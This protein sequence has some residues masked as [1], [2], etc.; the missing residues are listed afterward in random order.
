MHRGRLSIY[1]LRFLPLRGV[2]GDPLSPNGLRSGKLVT[3]RRNTSASRPY[4]IWTTRPWSEIVS[5]TYPTKP[6]WQG[7]SSFPGR[8]MQSPG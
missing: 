6:Y 4:R 8:W 7:I 3:R 1:G 5:V 2:A